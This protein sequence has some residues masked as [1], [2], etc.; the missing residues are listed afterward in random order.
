MSDS[1]W[2]G[3][4]SIPWASPKKPPRD[5]YD[6]K[7]LGLNPVTAVKNYGVFAG[8]RFLCLATL[9]FASLVWLAVTFS[10]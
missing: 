2:A 3:A 5:S 4:S 1:R 10:A 8:L 9:L 7:H 6:I